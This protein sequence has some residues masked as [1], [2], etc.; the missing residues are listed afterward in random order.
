MIVLMVV[1]M[2]GCGALDYDFVV[3][4]GGADENGKVMK[5]MEVE[6]LGG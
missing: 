6:G 4:D 1:L 3:E 2:D 5:W